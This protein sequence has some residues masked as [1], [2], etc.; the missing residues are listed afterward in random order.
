MHR[1]AVSLAVP[2][3][4]SLVTLSG[5]AASAEEQGPDKQIIEGK[6]P[7]SQTGTRAWVGVSGAGRTHVIAHALGRRGEETSKVD[8]NVGPDGSFKLEVARGSRYVVEIADGS[9]HVALMT[10]QDG[11]GVY[12]NAIPVAVT[13]DAKGGVIQVGKLTV[14]GKSAAP[15]KNPWLQLDA[16][17]R[18]AKWQLDA[19]FFVSI[20]G[21]VRDAQEAAREAV[22]EAEEAARQARVAADEARD[23]AEEARKA[24]EAA[25]GGF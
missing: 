24:A 7:V 14:V 22:K 25:R 23:A 12:T 1:F 9:Q 16:A 2:A 3:F 4:V 11:D 6:V 8:V 17:S 21:A 13:A 5:C 20:D 19:D 10:F 18:A 15:E